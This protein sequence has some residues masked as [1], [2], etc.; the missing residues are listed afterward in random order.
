[1]RLRTPN[2]SQRREQRKPNT[3]VSKAMPPED[4]REA[5]KVTETLRYGPQKGV[6]YFFSV[7]YLKQDTKLRK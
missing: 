3:W 1:M 6:R 5:R 7:V 4:N 2:G